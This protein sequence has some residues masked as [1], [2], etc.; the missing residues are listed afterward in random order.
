MLTSDGI[1][2]FASV[3]AALAAVYGVVQGIATYADATRVRKLATL[4]E[5][6]NTFQKTLPLFARLENDQLYESEIRPAIQRSLDDQ[7]LDAQ[8]LQIEADLEQA[9][10]F[11]YILWFRVGLLKDADDLVQVYKYYLI[12]LSSRAEVRTYVDQYY[13]GLLRNLGEAPAHGAPR[14]S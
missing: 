1:T 3:V 6:E 4:M 7:S 5:L 2:A 10:R 13:P 11:F 9:I 14:N 8:Q 12:V